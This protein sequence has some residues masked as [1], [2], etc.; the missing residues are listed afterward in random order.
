VTRWMAAAAAAVVLAASATAHAA[1]HGDPVRF[2]ASIARSGAAGRVSAFIPTDPL[3]P[4]QWYLTR[5]R[6]FE[7]WKEL[8]AL[9]PVRVAVIDSGVDLGHPDLAG[10]IV[11]AR[12][13][14]GGSARD[15]SGHGTAVAGIVAAKVG[16]GVGIA[17]LSPAAELLVA[18]VVDRDGSIRVEAEAKAIRWA[19][20]QG[21][22][23]INMSL[24]GVRDPSNPVQD[25]YSRVEADAIAY[26]I[27]HGVVVVA[28]VGNGDQAPSEPWRYAFYPAALPHVLGVSA[29]GRDGG[30]PGYSNRDPVYNDI[31]APGEDIV[32]TFPRGLTGRRPTCPEQG[33]TPCATADFR[34]A[35]G[36][37]FAAPQVTAAAA[38]LLSLRPELRPEQVTALLERSAVDAEPAS[39]CRRCPAGRDAFAGWGTLDV[40]AAITALDGSLPTVD[41]DEPNDDLGEAAR[42]LSGTWERRVVSATTDFWDDQDDIY[43]VYLGSGR[44]V[45]VSLEGA[46]GD[47]SLALWRPGAGSVQGP[48]PQRGRARLSARRGPREHL[49][50]RADAKGWHYVQVRAVAPGD[51]SYRLTIVRSQ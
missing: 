5:V 1:A 39:G 7:A 37:S 47:L 19:V 21:A 4:R 40:T 41:V 49:G 23:V 16:N 33:Y 25:T 8:P 45:D 36:T 22:R 43:G 35:D 6:A 20:A 28:A 3:A 9:D 17:G 26:A 31:G 51:T 38:T 50:F 13:F 15:T 12:S 48:L 42:R 44:R 2:G 34:P 11:A 32:S 30:V 46:S 27:S 10:R 18:K 24:G 14:V 29:V